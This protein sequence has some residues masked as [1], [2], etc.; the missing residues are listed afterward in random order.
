MHLLSIIVHNLVISTAKDTPVAR[1]GRMSLE[2]V[3]SS[4][5]ADTIDSRIKHAW[6][7]MGTRLEEAIRK[8]EV[9]SR[10]SLPITRALPY[11]LIHTPCVPEH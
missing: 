2:K 3:T 9:I 10:I 7:N 8:V 11:H 5:R 1:F 4:V 6:N